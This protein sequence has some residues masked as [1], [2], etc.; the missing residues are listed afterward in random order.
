MIIGITG[1]CED[2]KKNRCMMS[3]GKNT[4]MN[5]LCGHYGYMNVALADEIKRTAKRW[6][7]KFTYEHLWG[8]SEKRNEEVEVA[9]G[10]LLSAR[11]AC[12][13]IGTEVARVI[14]K[15]IWCRTFIANARLV[16]ECKHS[17]APE[18]G[19]LNRMTT[20]P[21]GVGCSD[22][23]FKNEMQYIQANGGKVVRVRRKVKELPEGV[24]LSHQS[25]ID[26]LDVPDE[27]F[28][29][30]IK[31]DQDVEYLKLRG[32]MMLKDLKAP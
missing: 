14:D 20:G 21:S 26:L 7:P 12:Q 27:E 10:V 23:R 22:M 5:H 6:W 9:P 15:D 8:P 1:I 16:W 30:V 24:D 25:E 13:Q 31:N 11:H 32:D 29:Y 28:D 17:Y 19:V 18:T 3:S 2:K 4:L